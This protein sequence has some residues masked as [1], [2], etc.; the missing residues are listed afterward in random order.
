MGQIPVS[1]QTNM[2]ATFLSLFTTAILDYLY[3]FFYFENYISVT[4]W[5]TRRPLLCLEPS[6]VA[7]QMKID[8][9]QNVEN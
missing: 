4:L 7:V 9:S 3:T 1:L 6:G 2:Y 8:L 5:T